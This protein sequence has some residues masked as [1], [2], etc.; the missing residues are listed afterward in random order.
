MYDALLCTRTSWKIWDVKLRMLFRTRSS[1]NT[2]VGTRRAWSYLPVLREVLY[3]DRIWKNS[4]LS[5]AHF[6]D[7]LGGH[8][9]RLHQ[10]GVLVSA[11]GTQDASMRRNCWR[12]T[13][14]T[15]R[16][17]PIARGNCST[18][19]TGVHID[20]DVAA[21]REKLREKLCWTCHEHDIPGR[22]GARAVPQRHPTPGL[23][24]RRAAQSTRQI[25]W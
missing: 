3:V 23:P 17:T 16:R 11:V 13:W 24:L 6:E 21:S 8:G 15:C 5:K 20:E 4:V 7:Q 12:S 19:K 25:I 2:T 9:F 10:L 22:P 14:P 1:W 18:P